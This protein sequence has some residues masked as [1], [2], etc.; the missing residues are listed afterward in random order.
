MKN[1]TDQQHLKWSL[2]TW[3]S[4]P[5]RKLFG[6]EALFATRDNDHQNF[7]FELGKI[8]RKPKSWAKELEIAISRLVDEHGSRLA[9]FYSG[10]SDSEVVLRTM[11]KLGVRPEIHTIQF[12]SDLNSHETQHAH[13]LC[14]SLGLK[15]IVWNHDVASYLTNATYLELGRK[16]QCSQ[17]AYLTVLEYARR[18]QIPV[19]MGG[20]IYL[21]RHQHSDGRVHSKDDW[22]YIYREDEDGV[23]YRYS[24]DTGHPII[25]EIMTYTPELL[26]AWMI[27][28]KIQEVV[29]NQLWGKITILSIK[30]QIYEQELGLSLTAQT[31][32]HGYEKL[33]WSNIDCREN[34]RQYLPRMQTAKVEYHTLMNSLRGK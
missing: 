30:R 20:E 7:R 32:F 26:Y 17:I 5:D 13:S 6:S 19:V 23:T 14:A 18:V 28:P 33:P 15:P 9:L 24:K 10:G 22:Y 12:S 3:T 31:K 4:G 1:L 2:H 25:N 34:L 27:H 11:T 21:Q 29:S 16:Y 8:S